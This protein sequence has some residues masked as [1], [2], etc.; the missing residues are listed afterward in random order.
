[1]KG[2][3]IAEWFGFGN[4]ASGRSFG[5]AGIDTVTTVADP[6]RELA[7]VFVTTDGPKPADRE[8]IVRIRNTV[9]NRVIEA[10]R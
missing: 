8:N 6:E 2:D 5:H 7:I 9:T 10:I 4:R 1:L 3:S